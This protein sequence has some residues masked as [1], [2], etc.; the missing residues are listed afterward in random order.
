MIALMHL[1]NYFSKAFLMLSGPVLFT[2][3]SPPHF[4]AT[5]FALFAGVYHLSNEFLKDLIGSIIAI[6]LN[7]TT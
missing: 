7:I 2:K 5:T 3:L 1:F 6:K 4:E